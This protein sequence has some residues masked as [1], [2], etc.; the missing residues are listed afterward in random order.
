M[1]GTLAYVLFLYVNGQERQEQLTSG[2]SQTMLDLETL[3]R[4]VRLLVRVFLC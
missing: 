4:K 2:A 3:V 1:G